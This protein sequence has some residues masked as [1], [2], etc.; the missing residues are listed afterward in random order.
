MPPESEKDGK[1]EDEAQKDEP[2]KEKPDDSE[3][4]AGEE[5]SQEKT[6]E[7]GTKTDAKVGS[8]TYSI[9]L[10]E[11]HFDVNSKLVYTVCLWSGSKFCTAHIQERLA[12]TDLVLKVTIFLLLKEEKDKEKS[13]N[14]EA[15]KDVEKKAKSQ[16]KSKISEDI[17]VEL[18]INDILNP[19]ADDVTSSKKK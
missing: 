16:K 8:V 13:G 5:K 11:N 19:T 18:V 15:E 1:G 14:P 3:K 6:D 12:S 17:S 7:A 4:S 9:C 10:S 2:A